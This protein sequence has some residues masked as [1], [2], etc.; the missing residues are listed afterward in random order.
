MPNKACQDEQVDRKV[1]ALEEGGQ[2]G[3]ELLICECR[4]GKGLVD[5]GTLSFEGYGTRELGKPGREVVSMAVDYSWVV[6]G[7]HA[8]GSNG[9]DVGAAGRGDWG[10]VAT[11]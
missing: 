11:E 6:M 4:L 10:S 5:C 2:E 1:V 8:K 9:G 3:W 7:C